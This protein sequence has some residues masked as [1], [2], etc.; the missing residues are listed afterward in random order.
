MTNTTTDQSPTSIADSDSARVRS[1]I[2]DTRERLGQT[3][4][5]IGDRVIP[6][7]IIE[8]RKES[9]ANSLR[10]L[11]DRIMGTAQH[12]RD[13]VTDSAGSTVDHLRAAP[14]SVAQHTEGSPLAVGGV[15][16]AIGFL[17]AAVWRPT[18]PERQAVET[19]ADAAP[20]LTAGVAAI[21]H[22]VADSVKDEA[23]G[24]AEELKASVADAGAAVK[25]AAS[26]DDGESS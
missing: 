18:A 6:G 4:D 21:G 1:E 2:D 16:F 26:P 23:L 10:G 9:T 24:A 14:G 12:A 5:A 22:E 11:R 17:A 8:R 19:V 3:V 20:E 15:A 13:E 25:S 7:R